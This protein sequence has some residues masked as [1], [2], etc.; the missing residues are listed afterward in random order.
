MK[1]AMKSFTTFCVQKC[2]CVCSFLLQF[3]LYIQLFY[4]RKQS[5]V[6]PDPTIK[7]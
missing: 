2:V 7:P 6:M 4:S 5:I 3:C 1:E